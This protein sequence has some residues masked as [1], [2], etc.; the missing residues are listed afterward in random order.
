MNSEKT[1]YI[2]RVESERPYTYGLGEVI[3]PNVALFRDGK[4]NLT[5]EQLDQVIKSTNTKQGPKQ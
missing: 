5:T 3:S 2:I 1:T 4:Y